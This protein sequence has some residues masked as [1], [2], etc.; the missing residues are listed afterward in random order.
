MS[1]PLDNNLIKKPHQT[2]SWTEQQI[3]EIAQCCD[4][5]TGP[6]Y[7][8]SN[9]F[10]I[11]HP[12]K[13]KLLYQPFE[14]QTRFL[15]V[16]TNHRFSVAMQPRQTGKSTTAAGYLLWFAMF[17]PDSTVLI[18][19][20]K[21]LGAQEIMQ[22]I[23]FAY[24]N[25]PDHI[26][27]GVTS[28]NKGSIEFE[29]GS[30]IVAQTTT[31]TTGRG[32]SI[33]CL[34]TK[35]TVVTVRD[36]ITGVVAQK[37]LSDLVALQQADKLNH[38]VLTTA[39]FK[40]FDAITLVLRD[41]FLLQLEHSSVECT[42]DH[43]FFSKE[44]NDWVEFREITAGE[45][46]QTMSGFE[47]C[48]SKKYLGEQAVSDLVNVADVH[49]FIANGINVHNC[50]FLD[51]FAYVRPTVAREFWVSISPTLST[52]GKAI[53]TSTPNSDE[54]QFATIWKQANKCTDEW[55]NPTE[56]GVNGF[57]AVRSYWDEHPDRDEKWKQEEIGR[58][59]EERFRRE[60]ECSFLVAEESLINS[61]TLSEL[62]HKEP[63]FKQGQVRWYSEPKKDCVYVVALDPSLGTGGDMAAIEVFESPS[64]RQIA[65]WQNNRTPIQ[66]Q[67]Q[68]LKEICKTLSETVPTTNIYYSVENNTLGEAALVSINEIG[69]ENIAG[70]FL[71]EPAR[72]GQSRRYRKGFTTTSKSKL[73]ACAKLKS[74]IESKKMHIHSQNLISE[75]KTFVSSGVGFAAKVGETDDLVSASLLVVRMVQHLKQFHP[76]LDQQIS[77][78]EEFIEPMPF[79]AVIM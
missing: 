18:A 8:C 43:R 55:G 78:R 74:L 46:V 19:A 63:T 67:I 51:E 59:G 26:R 50:L 79:I 1:K 72:M 62:T 64:M 45:F 9:F 76:E 10:Y 61:M 27:A 58:I 37:T 57:R 75:L 24:E 16:M 40:H 3:L 29:N 38:T 14:Y 23:R 2:A 30:R 47:K 25:T 32:M 65:E 60:H 39:G 17:N 5:V 53:I 36:S 68:I 66:K 31:E 33:S 44:R 22:R 56:V 41:T 20:H 54:D 77:D 28:Y 35:N 11:Q 73:A 49:S 48:V 13:G 12:T 52:G 15:T 34:S 7:F 70:V 21:Y 69:E 4:P 6:H 42:S 71:S